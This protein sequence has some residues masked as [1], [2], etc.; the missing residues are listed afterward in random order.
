MVQNTGTLFGIRLAVSL[1]PAAVS[2]LTMLVIGLYN[3]DAKRME[4]IGAELKVRRE[5]APAAVSTN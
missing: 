1:L 5:T 4:Q 3:L 2:I